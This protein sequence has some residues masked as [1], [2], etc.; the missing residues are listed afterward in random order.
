[1][2]D[3]L[4]KYAHFIPL[5]HPYTTIGVAQIFFDQVFK[6]H[7]MRRSMIS[8]VEYCY[9][10]SW[11]LA[12]KTMSFDVVYGHGRPPPSLMSCVSGSAKVEAVERQLL[13]RDQKLKELR[14]TLKE[15]QNRMKKVYDNHH[16]ERER[17]LK[18]SSRYY[19]SY[20]VIKRIGAVAYKLDLLE[21]ARIRRFHVSLL[22]KKV[23]EGI[24]V[25]T[26]LPFRGD[27]ETLH[28]RPQAV[29]D[30]RV[31]KRKRQILIH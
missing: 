16:H 11:H 12:I 27:D 17:N 14:S 24:M 25:Q 26:E 22:K 20:R 30:Q 7:G 5:S 6:L 10:T 8:W 29:L 21:E 18:L 1:M 2:V 13:D 3:R 19:G 15:A 31:H 28:P 9:N 4:S 23:G